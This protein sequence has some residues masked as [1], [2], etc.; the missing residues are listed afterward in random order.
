MHEPNI[1]Y[2]RQS[3]QYFPLHSLNFQTEELPDPT[4]AERIEASELTRQIIETGLLEE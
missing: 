3:E 2:S 1:D 4:L